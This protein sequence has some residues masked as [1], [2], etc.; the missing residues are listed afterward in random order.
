MKTFKYIDGQGNLI[1]P[2]TLAS[3][4]G[5]HKAGI[6]GDATQVI[7]EETNRCLTAGRLLAD[8]SQGTGQAPSV[9]ASPGQPAQAR[10]SIPLPPPPPAAD[11]NSNTGRKS[12]IPKIGK[13]GW[14]GVVILILGLMTFIGANKSAEDLW[15]TTWSSFG[16]DRIIVDESLAKGAGYS[17][18]T[19]YLA[20]QNRQSGAMFSAI[21]LG[22]VIW[23]YVRYNSKKA[24]V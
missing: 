5:L 24:A 1:G 17:S 19:D 9:V 2:A 11:A 21:G 4:Q 22:L 14:G 7:D 16:S 20:Q 12:G 15:H 13:R 3:L 8:Q 23:G 6:I 10:A 18:Y